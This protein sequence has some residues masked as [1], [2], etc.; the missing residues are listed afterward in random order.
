MGDGPPPFKCYDCQPGLS[1]DECNTTKSEV[2]CPGGY[3]N[4]YSLSADLVNGS[5]NTPSAKLG[6]YKSSGGPCNATCAT[7]NATLQAGAYFSRCVVEC[8]NSA[9][10]NNADFPVL[11]ALP[12]VTPTSESTTMTTGTREP[13]TPTICSQAPR[14]PGS[15]PVLIVVFGALVGFAALK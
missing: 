4:C 15:F 7:V 6:C 10:C 8:C 12:T 2:T 5:V 3:D 11:P 1:P 9:K 13:G 14:T